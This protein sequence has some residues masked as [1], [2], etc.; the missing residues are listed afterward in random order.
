[1]VRFGTMIFVVLS[2]VSVSLA[3]EYGGYGSAGSASVVAQSHGSTGSTAVAAAS[4]GCSGAAPVAAFGST[5][6]DVKTAVY[7]R[8]PIRTAIANRPKLRTVSM[9]G[10]TCANCTCSGESRGLGAGSATAAPPAPPAAGYGPAAAKAQSIA[11]SGRLSHAGALVGTY[12]GIGYSTRSADEAI[13]SCC[14]WG[15]R[16]PV[17]IGVARGSGGWYAVVGYR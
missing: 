10:C 17:D 12:E 4:Y 2:M 1:M 14:Y 9:A 15:A 6:S 13:R 5:G 11:A 8:A 7:R 3:G 16:Q